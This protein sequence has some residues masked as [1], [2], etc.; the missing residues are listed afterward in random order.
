MEITRDQHL[1]KV[2]GLE[3]FLPCKKKNLVGVYL[4][5]LRGLNHSQGQ[6]GDE[7]GVCVRRGSVG[8]VTVF[9]TPS[10][11]TRMENSKSRSA[12][13]N[14]DPVVGGMAGPSH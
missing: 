3:S 8:A 9:A 6:S 2:G 7:R 12:V 13:T 10:R 1:T 11:T 14:S 5:I 4:R